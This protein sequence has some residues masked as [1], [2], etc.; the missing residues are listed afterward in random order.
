MSGIW[1]AP[2]K[3][4]TLLKGALVLLAGF[5]AAICALETLIYFQ[6]RPL[7][8]GR[9]IADFQGHRAAYERLRE[10]I[11]ADQQV[12]EVSMKGVETPAAPLP[13]NPSEVNF[14]LARYREYMAILRNIDKGAVFRAEEKQAKLVCVGVWG[15]GWAGDTRHQWVCWSSSEPGNQVASLDDY[16]RNPKRSRNVFR[17]IEGNWYLRADW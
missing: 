15:A 13:W 12:E 14:P 3:G 5:A 7:K 16:Y 2:I 17:H 4:K 10:M 9:I 6:M 8:E 1:D 11:L